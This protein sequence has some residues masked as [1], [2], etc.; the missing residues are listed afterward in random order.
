MKLFNFAGIHRRSNFEKTLKLFYFSWNSR[1][2]SKLNSNLS[3]LPYRDV[4]GLGATVVSMKLHSKLENY[5][6]D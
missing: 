3:I 1:A 2:D 4:T 6:N 5:L